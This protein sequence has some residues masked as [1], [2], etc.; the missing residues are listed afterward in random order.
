MSESYLEVTKR[1]RQEAADKKQREAELNGAKDDSTAIVHEIAKQG[2]KS[3]T[4]TQKV[5]LENEDLAKADDVQE[6]VDSI[7]RLN[8]TTFLASKDNWTTVV[9]EMAGAA[10]RIQSVID[11]LETGGVKKIETSFSAAVKSLQGVVAQLKTVKVQNDDD[12]KKE[13]QAVTK[14]VQA[15]AF[16]PVIKVEAPNVTL[17]ERE[18]DFSP[19]RESLAAFIPESRI[20]LSEYRAQDLDE[21][22]PGVQFVGM[23]NPNGDWYIIKNDEAENSLRYKFG[24][25]KYA[26]AWAKISTFAYKHLD[27]AINEVQA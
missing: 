9:E 24:K 21:M 13:L 1:K 17:Q 18:I 15:L 8:V 20:D 27:E 25:G 2:A 11:G 5:K 22:E 14:A 12:V 16:D 3:R 26:S 23:L 19:I 7:N 6:V 10:E 4:T